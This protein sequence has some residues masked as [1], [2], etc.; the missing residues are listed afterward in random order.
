[1]RLLLFL[2]YYGIALLMGF[3]L[4]ARFDA[5]MYAKPHMQER[6]V[7]WSADVVALVDS[8]EAIDG[9][10]LPPETTDAVAFSPV[11][12]ETRLGRLVRR[13]ERAGSGGTAAGGSAA[14][15]GGVAA[16]PRQAGAQDVP[17]RVEPA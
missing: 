9:P 2:G 14:G 17:P 3:V 7:V 5:W 6:L 4:R 12:G 8:G 16:G 13:G 15:A 11:V 10:L 1:M